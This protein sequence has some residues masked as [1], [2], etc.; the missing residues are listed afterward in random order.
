LTIVYPAMRRVLQFLV[1]AGLLI[2]GCASP[3]SDS[4]QVAPGPEP[5]T[6]E[7]VAPAEGGDSAPGVAHATIGS[8]PRLT[9]VGDL[10]LSGQPGPQDF[11]ALA[12]SGVGMVINLRHPEE[13]GGFDEAAAVRAEGMEYISI[14]WNGPTE[15]SDAVFEQTR[16][17]LRTADGPV[18]L[19]CA[20]ANR[21]GA[22]WIPF[23]VLDQGVDIEQAVT[24][25]RMVGMRVPEYE[26]LARAF[27][28]R[29]R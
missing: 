21:V 17:L 16:E 23:R 2:T 6:T 4:N 18:L 25:A 3:A 8:I 7:G 19:H 24:E 22:A 1:F 12:A 28:D 15:L 27:V 10:L 11:A 13:L 9:Q 14:P 5:Q 29:N 20:S 26:A